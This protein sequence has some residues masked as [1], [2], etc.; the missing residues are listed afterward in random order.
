M[1]TTNEEGDDTRTNSYVS[2]LASKYGQKFMI[3][4]IMIEM[5]EGASED[6]LTKMYAK[7]RYKEI[8]S[9]KQKVT[10]ARR[11]VLQ[12]ALR[13]AKAR[14]RGF[15][16]LSPAPA[17]PQAADEQ[18]YYPLV[19]FPVMIKRIQ[20]DMARNAHIRNMLNVSNY[21]SF[22]A[23]KDADFIHILH[24][25]MHS[26]V[27]ISSQDIDLLEGKL[28]FI[29]FMIKNMNEALPML[30][31]VLIR[32]SSKNSVAILR[33]MIPSEQ[34]I[35][36]IEKYLEN[37]KCALVVED[38]GS[39][40]AVLQDA[41]SHAQM[42]LVVD[43]LIRDGDAYSGDQR[44]IGDIDLG[45]GLGASASPG[46][47]PSGGAGEPGDSP[48][49]DVSNRLL[50]RFFHESVARESI[51]IARDRWKSETELFMNKGMS[52]EE[53][54][55]GYAKIDVE[56]KKRIENLFARRANVVGEAEAIR[57]ISTQE[58]IQLMN[59]K[60]ETRYMIKAVGFG[61]KAAAAAATTGATV[62]AAGFRK[63]A[64]VA[65]SFVDVLM[66]V[67]KMIDDT[68]EQIAMSASYEAAFMGASGGL[69]DVNT[70]R[71]SLDMHTHN[72]DIEHIVR[73][74]RRFKDTIMPT[75]NEH[76]RIIKEREL[77]GYISLLERRQQLSQDAFEETLKKALGAQLNI[78]KAR[79]DSYSHDR[80]DPT[81]MSA[82][83]LWAMDD[84][85]QASKLAKT[86]P[87]TL[88]RVLSFA[89]FQSETNYTWLFIGL[90]VGLTSGILSSL[91]VIAALPGGVTGSLI[92]GTSGVIG[93]FFAY[94]TSSIDPKNKSMQWV[95]S[96]I[97]SYAFSFVF[98]VLIAYM[99][100]PAAGL[101]AAMY[102]ASYFIASSMIMDTLTWIVDKIAEMFSGALDSENR[103]VA[104]MRRLIDAV[105]S[106]VNFDFGL[107]NKLSGYRA[108]MIEKYP[109]TVRVY[110]FLT[111]GLRR[112][113]TRTQFIRTAIIWGGIA[114]L[115]RFSPT[116]ASVGTHKTAIMVP[117]KNLLDF[118]GAK[119]SNAKKVEDSIGIL[120]LT[121]LV[122]PINDV[123]TLQYNGFYDQSEAL[124]WKQKLVTGVVYYFAFKAVSLEWLPTLSFVDKLSAPLV[125][126]VAPHNV[127]DMEAANK[128]WVNKKMNADSC[129]SYELDTTSN[130]E[131][132]STCGIMLEKNTCYVK[133]DDGSFATK[134]TREC[135][136]A[137]S[138]FLKGDVPLSVGDMSVDLAKLDTEATKLLINQVEDALNA[139]NK[140]DLKP[141]MEQFGL[142]T[143]EKAKQKIVEIS[144]KLSRNVE[145]RAQL[146]TV[147]SSTPDKLGTVLT[148]DFLNKVSGST[149]NSVFSETAAQVG[150]G[151][152]M[153][154]YNDKK[155]NPVLIDVCMKNTGVLKKM[156]DASNPEVDASGIKIV[157]SVLGSVLK[158]K[159]DETSLGDLSATYAR[160]MANS[161]TTNTGISQLRL[162]LSKITPSTTVSQQ[163][164]EWFFSFIE[165]KENE[166]DAEYLLR[167]NT[168]MAGAAYWSPVL[169]FVTKVG[170]GV[171]WFIGTTALGV[172]Y[173][174]LSWTL[175]WGKDKD[176]KKKKK[177]TVFT[178]G[179]LSGPQGRD[180][181]SARGQTDILR[182]I[183][184]AIARGPRSSGADVAALISALKADEQKQLLAMS[185]QMEL[186]PQG[187]A[188]AAD[189]S[190]KALFLLQ[191]FTYLP[192]MRAKMRAIVRTR[193]QGFEFSV[194]DKDMREYANAM[195]NSLIDA[196][197]MSENDLAAVQIA[198]LR[199]DTIHA[200][201]IV[202]FQQKDVPALC[203]Q[204]NKVVR[205]ASL[206][207]IMLPCTPYNVQAY[208][209]VFALF[210]T[211]SASA[212]SES[213]DVKMSL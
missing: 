106:V 143:T 116:F 86:S 212:A 204:I 50:D 18:L 105:V 122:G 186:T 145:F 99:L 189:E 168:Y 137:R 180:R 49:F 87:F 170:W 127:A 73:D 93:S 198:A 75:I 179:L 141:F 192:F 134:L 62:A 84:A 104:A 61:K 203:A 43:E 171:T 140:N 176:D 132:E 151:A 210:M 110:D 77:D 123:L 28:A 120:G 173:K 35:E 115:T 209:D 67:Q 112:I 21:T 175:G 191:N 8:E 149:L 13:D 63:I 193:A 25:I 174:L 211:A 7:S 146:E 79:V 97:A 156:V 119:P 64:S 69:Y 37:L 88:D 3:C 16:A 196:P 81:Q 38:A 188:L 208:V 54:A 51:A 183:A 95:M 114:L 96:K 32:Y 155:I 202:H 150:S 207:T 22:M 109:L 48:I 90:G 169:K 197:A 111:S 55:A 205:D 10:E 91:G 47:G 131:N 163:S 15:T 71:S 107:G 4:M 1:Q 177:G 85:F 53:I 92:L 72:S 14:A 24:E 80:G 139:I 44:S 185:V 5:L 33:E 135:K 26:S 199:L 12:S 2:P 89:T 201:Q 206:G 144:M 158:N 147:L 157:R 118:S 94:A 117:L 74:M 36:R 121:G 83:V 195:F 162:L 126:V 29:D 159:N 128:E 142:D 40:S 172:G 41:L 187:E 125:R 46:T 181:P 103:L 60:T 182:R 152:I 108:S 200:V 138:D 136:N 161:S 166:S 129:I 154:A 184:P 78:I 102:A 56:Y 65:R 42:Q 133:T 70:E 23:L 19:R 164:K 11:A 39:V 124:S 113:T 66:S 101:A 153:N 52:S 68:E 76:D 100:A 45:E 27:D 34:R 148:V 98:Q 6:F 20:W 178:T 31:D 160:E 17:A 130:Y 213:A 167:M 59:A 9:R 57:E 194:G 190:D 165:R 82:Y 58:Y 30:E